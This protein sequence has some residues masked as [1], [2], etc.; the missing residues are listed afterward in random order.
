MGAEAVVGRLICFLAV[1]L[2]STP[3]FVL[4][5]ARWSLGFWIFS[6]VGSWGNAGQKWWGSSRGFFFF[7][8][9]GSNSY[10]FRTSEKNKRD[11]WFVYWQPRRPNGDRENKLHRATSIFLFERSRSDR[12]LTV[13]LS[14]HVC[15]SWFY[16][17]FEFNT[18]TVK[19]Q[20]LLYFF[21]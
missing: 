1:S 16:W 11:G 20:Y 8:H 2:V 3:V 18:V 19:W 6:L 9:F 17:V 5:T 15:M 14:L 10:R 13:I 4:P 21:A 7:L 12:S